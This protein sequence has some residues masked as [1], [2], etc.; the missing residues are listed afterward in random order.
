MPKIESLESEYRD[1]EARLSASP[2]PPLQDRQALSK[3]HAE[4]APLMRLLSERRKVERDLEEA[5]ALLRGPDT[6]LHPLAEAE[7][8]QLA[9][10]LEE[11][12]SA[13]RVEL[14]PKDPRDSKN[15]FLEVR[16]G[17]GGDEAALFA[18]EL[19]RMYTRF[20][21][22]RGWRVELVE[23]VGTGLKGAKQATLHVKGPNA[24]AWLKFEGGVHRVQRVPVTEASG[25]IHTSTCTVAVLAEVEEVEVEVNPKDLRVDTYRAGGAGGQNVNKVETAIRITHV[26]TGIVVQC[27]DERSQ[28]QNR[29]KAMAILRAK[30]ASVARE[31]ALE[32][33]TQDRRQQV[34]SGDRSEKIRTYNFAQNRVTDHRLERSWHNLPEVLEGAL[35]P[36]LEALRK[37]AEEAQLRQVR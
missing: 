15:A 11:L 2:P 13:L 5:E 36:V 21:Q 16:A 31:K 37:E 20:A 9:R 32:K 34:G 3:R 22:M 30:L 23:F 17:A 27:Q 26:P 4:L 25:R 7:K 12:E 35:E 19:V 24:F 18:S 8:S 10:R 29:L 14:L 28:G 33:E 6:E 1:I